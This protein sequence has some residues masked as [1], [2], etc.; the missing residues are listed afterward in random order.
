MQAAIE[1][2]YNGQF[3]YVTVWDVDENG[4]IMAPRTNMRRNDEKE[5][6]A[7]SEFPISDPN[8][9]RFV[10][11]KTGE[12]L[13]EDH[14]SKHQDAAATI[15]DELSLG[16]AEKHSKRNE[17]LIL[18]NQSKIDIKKPIP[19]EEEQISDSFFDMNADVDYVRLVIH[20]VL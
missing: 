17:L 14:A 1:T 9:P 5:K 10:A 8:D 19:Q 15:S 4:N 11:K 3:R 6:L 16:Q 12:D 13:K 20:P 18:R 7:D 2:K